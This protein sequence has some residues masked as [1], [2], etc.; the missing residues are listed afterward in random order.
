MQLL[1]AVPPPVVV[2]PPVV[3]VVPLAATV[4]VL[5]TLHPATKVV[6]AKVI[7]VK[8]SGNLLCHAMI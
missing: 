6:A 2:V 4:S 3:A 1:L 5:P 8:D 7:A